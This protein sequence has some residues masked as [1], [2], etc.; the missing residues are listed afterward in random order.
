MKTY[1]ERKRSI[2]KK[3]GVRRWMRRALFSTTAM[4]CAFALF[5]GVP[6][7]LINGGFA[8][9]VPQNT[10]PSDTS[11]TVLDGTTGPINTIPSQPNST[12]PSTDTREKISVKIWVPEEDG[13]AD[14]MYAQIQRF[15]ETNQCDVEIDATVECVNPYEVDYYLAADPQNGADLYCFYQEDLSKMIELGLLQQL[16]TESNHWIKENHHE[17]A[18]SVVCS[19]QNAY[20][21]PMNLKDSY[22]LYYDKSVISPDDV[23]SLESI[24]AACEDSGRK[25]SYNLDNGYYLSA[26]FFATGCHSR[27]FM[28]N[29]EFVALDDTFDSEEGQIALQGVMKLLN[30]G[31]YQSPGNSSLSYEECYKQSAVIVDGLW[32]YEM[33]SGIWGDNL[34]VA[35]LPSFTVDGTSYTLRPF[36]S[37]AVMGMKPQTDSHRIQVLEKLARFLQ[38]GVCQA[39][40]Y[41]QV[42]SMIPTHY[43]AREN[44]TTVHASMQFAQFFD[45]E[46]I[47]DRHGSWYDVTSQLAGRLQ[48]GEA[49]ADVLA[50]YSDSMDKILGGIVETYPLWLELSKDYISQLKNDFLDQFNAHDE[51]ESLDQ[52][53][54][55]VFGVFDM[56]S[57]YDESEKRCVLFVDGVFLYPESETSETVDGITFNYG[58]GQKMYLYVNGHFYTLQ[59]AVHGL[60][61]CDGPYDMLMISHSELVEVYNNYIQIYPHFATGE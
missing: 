6:Q 51:V 15:N 22:L 56:S 24:I 50:W 45:A 35:C 9:L 57:L 39:E 37:A 5:I 44:I 40:R 42:E 26:F 59:E 2:M 36:G 34:G 7:L 31:C 46:P 19:D 41:A 10:A 30:S 38:S 58:S 32:N 27:W 48:N 4:V 54:L 13:L 49:P 14:L 17:F 43:G 1:D 52:I 29:G 60:I 55:R 12:D 8:L 28:E 16:S 18:Y 53:S 33:I 23:D 25:F 21:F 61:P 20:A 11:G 47:S 3:A